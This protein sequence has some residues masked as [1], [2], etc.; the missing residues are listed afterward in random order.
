MRVQQSLTVGALLSASS[1]ALVQGVSVALSFA[2][3]AAAVLP[4]F[5]CGAA[6]AAWNKRERALELIIDGRGNLSLEI[7]R[8]EPR[9]LLDPDHRAAL[10]RSLDGIQVEAEDPVHRRPLT[11]PVFSARAIAAVASD[12]TDIATRLGDDHAGPRG[13]AMTRR[14]L[15]DGT[16]P[17]YG[18]DVCL[19][20]E[21]LHRIR[22]HLEN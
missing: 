7:V 22:F 5:G 2:V 13:V 1:I 3:A 8:R 20:Q 15:F 11:T 9:R 21:E 14:L 4:V 18:E 10:A 19:L 16:S 17:L 6:V 12:L